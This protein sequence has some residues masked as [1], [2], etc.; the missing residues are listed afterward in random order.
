MQMF[1]LVI[2]HCSGLQVMAPNRKIYALKRI[3]LAGRDVE[4]AAGFI[5][6]ITLLQR[7]HSK[8]NII[9]LCD[10]EVGRGNDRCY[11]VLQFDLS[12]STCYFRPY[13]QPEVASAQV[14]PTPA[15]QAQQGNDG[16]QLLPR[17]ASN[18][19]QLMRQLPARPG[20]DAL[21][22][23]SQVI[24]SEGLIYMVLEYGDIDLARLL[25]KHEKSRGEGH[26]GTVDENFIR[27]YWQQMLQVH[28]I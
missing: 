13:G 14:M 7:L 4:A 22:L 25:A 11:L 1:D 27:L 15:L 24:Q 20:A 21:S 3:R 17:Q 16:D 19:K 18:G 2:S 6:E 10:A 26:A 28:G 23:L 12:A 8:Q 5:D 9:Q